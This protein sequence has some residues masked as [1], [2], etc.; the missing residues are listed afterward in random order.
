MNYVEFDRLSSPHLPRSR[1]VY[2]RRVFAPSP[3]LSPTAVFLVSRPFHSN[4]T[5]RGHRAASMDARRPSARGSRVGPFFRFR[6]LFVRWRARPA[7]TTRLCAGHERARRARSPKPLPPHNNHHPLL[8]PDHTINLYTHPP[9]AQSRALKRAALARAAS[10]EWPTAEHVERA[11]PDPQP[12]RVS[13]LPEHLSLTPGPLSSP[14]QAT[15]ELVTSVTRRLPASKRRRS[16]VVL[17]LAV[18]SACRDRISRNREPVG[19]GA[20]CFFAL[21][22]CARRKTRSLST[23]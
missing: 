15:Q 6:K 23:R 11:H 12:W 1:C 19:M 5:Q 7:G 14:L 21:Q 22:G 20:R 4:C 2:M 8:P 17:R 3:S 16:L 10:V 9:P 13:R 18:E